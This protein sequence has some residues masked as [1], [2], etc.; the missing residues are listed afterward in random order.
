M[1]IFRSKDN[2]SIIETPNG[3]SRTAFENK[4]AVCTIS[5]HWEEGK[6]DKWGQGVP[7]PAC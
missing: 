7:K 2:E 3:Q 5:K 1:Y 6:R 4:L